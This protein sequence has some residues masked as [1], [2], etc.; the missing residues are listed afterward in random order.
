M[1]PLSQKQVVRLGKGIGAMV[2]RFSG[3]RKKTALT[4]LNII[5][6]DS[7][8]TSQKMKRIKDSFK[9]LAVSAM[10][11][12]WVT[13][14]TEERVR[15]LIPKE[16]EGLDLLKKCLEKKKGVLFLT[17]HYGNWEVMGLYHG[18]LEICPLSSIVRK[19]DNPYLDNF[20]TKMRTATGNQIFYRDDSL[21]KIVRELKNKHS[22]AVMMDQNTARGSI[23][24]NFLD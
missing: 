16:P 12:I 19:L 14:N 13:I 15:Q 18:L 2:F 6:S 20:T 21:L 4:N 24:V 9:L 8:T 11:S 1:R 22:V 7:Q 5:F 3:K 10:Q 17:A 23:F